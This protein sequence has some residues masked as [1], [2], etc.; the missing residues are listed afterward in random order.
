MSNI[1]SPDSGFNNA[2]EII[3]NLIDEASAIQ[4]E[5]AGASLS[6]AGANLS[7]QA[8]INAGAASMAEANYNI[9][10]DQVQTS[11]A[12]SAMTMTIMSSM[13]HNQALLGS[14]GILGSSK[15]YLSIVDQNLN[16]FS[17][18]IIQTKNAALARQQGL[19][20]E[21]QLANMNDKN[22]ASEATFQGEMASYNAS[23]AE[24]QQAGKMV[25][26][27]FSAL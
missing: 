23:L 27:I 10:L 3:P 21:G 20:Y 26:Q 9:Q 5:S 7:A 8:Y 14:N 11:Q 12:L 17:T 2:L 4:S 24:S 1:F 19:Y 18:N 22:M 6:A 13:G 16:N 25:G 15:S